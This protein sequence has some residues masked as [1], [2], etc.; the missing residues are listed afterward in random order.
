VKPAS[1]TDRAGPIGRTVPPVGLQDR[2]PAL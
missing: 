1:T 2:G